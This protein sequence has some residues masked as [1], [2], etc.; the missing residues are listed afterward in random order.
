MVSFL[1][2]LGIHNPTEVTVLHIR[3]FILFKQKHCGATTIYNYFRDM[4]RFFNWLIEESV[5]E[6]SPMVTLRPPRR[7]KTIIEPFR[8]DQIARLLMLCDESTFLGARNKA[9]VL[10]F[11][12]TG[13]RLREL[14]SIQLPDVDFDREII[15]VMGKGAKERIVRIGKRTQRALLQYLLLRSDNLPCLWVTEERTPLHYWGVSIAVHRLCERA[16]LTG[17][18]GSPHTFRHTFATNS[19]LN[20]ARED[21]VQSLLGHSTPY[22]TMRYRATL[23]SRQAVEGHKR[24]SPVDRLKLK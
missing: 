17:V 22:M 8:D 13:L 6:R 15:K 12:D 4:R 24:F 5:I 3:L 16:K 18:R 23:D 9:I 1:S 19:L 7:P 20:G 10:T 21:E 2:S 11:L 14:S